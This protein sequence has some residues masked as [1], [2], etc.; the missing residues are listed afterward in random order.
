V[1][2]Y[3]GID[4]GDVWWEGGCVCCFVMGEVFSVVEIVELV[5]D[6][7]GLV[8][9]GLYC[10]VVVDLGSDVVMKGMFVLVMNILSYYVY[11]V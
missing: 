2:D 6:F 4:V 3:F 9:N 1:V 10:V 8:G 7:G 5:R 11:V